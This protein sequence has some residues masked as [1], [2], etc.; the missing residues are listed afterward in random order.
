MFD[1]DYLKG[2]KALALLLDP[3]KTVI[4]SSWVKII[5]E[6]KPD[7]I[8]IGGSQPFAYSLLDSMVNILKE[9][10]SVPIIG[11]PGAVNQIHPKYDALLALSVVQSSDPKFILAPIFQV[12]DLVEELSISSFFTPYIILG[13]TGHTAVEKVLDKKIISLSDAE[14]VKSYMLGLKIINPACV[15][16]EAGS[17]SSQILSS[18]YVKLASE[19]LIPS[20]LFAGGGVRSIHDAMEL[21][22]AGADCLVV[23]N[24][25]EE[26]PHALHELARARDHVN[27]SSN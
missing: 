11:F 3:D 7:L 26:S 9:N 4:D 24:W 15:Y 16:L 18:N 25:I 17:G 23:G 27:S 8:L 1:F 5:Q 2:S 20:Y 14:I 13:T 19:I 12:A 6:A 22:R 21:W 10:L